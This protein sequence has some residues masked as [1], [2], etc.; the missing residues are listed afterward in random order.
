[1]TPWLRGAGRSLK[2]PNKMPIQ[3]KAGK[4]PRQLGFG[5]AV[6]SDT[7]NRFR[8]QS[9]HTLLVIVYQFWE[10]P[11]FF[12]LPVIIFISL[13]FLPLRFPPSPSYAHPV[14]SVW[15]LER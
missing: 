2:F 10:E 1:M 4:I 14:K 8:A 15:V 13:C 3:G 9:G 11:T 12:S 6:L 5:E 7:E